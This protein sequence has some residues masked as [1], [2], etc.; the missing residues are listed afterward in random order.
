MKV[1]LG[2]PGTGKTTRLIN[3]VE[4]YLT[5][6]V[7]PDRIGYFAFTRRAAEEAIDRA[8]TQFNLSK[9]ELP[10]FRTLHSLAFLRAGLTHS[11]VM[12]PEKYQE[13]ADWLKI[14]KFYSGSQVEQGPYKDFG[15]GDKFLEIINIARIL[16]KPLRKIYNESIVPLKT[17][18]AR[19]DYVDRGLAHWKKSYGLQDY[20]G[21]LELFVEQELC[22]KLEIVFIDEAQDLSPLQWEM[23]R[24]LE[25][26][27]KVCYVAGDDDQAIFRY[28]GADVEHFIGLEGEVT[29]LNQ[30]YRIPTSHHTLSSKVIK[31][32]VGRREKTFKPR[33]ENGD[34]FWHRHSE[35]VDLSQGDWLL[36]SRT[37][38][39]AQQIEEEVRR[40]GH[41]YIYNGST[42]IDGKVIESVR[43][44]ESL[45][46]GNKLNV[47]Q[48]RLVYKQMLLNSQITY[49]FKTMPDG[50]E[51]VF[52]SIEELQQNHGLLHSFPW[53][54]G[55]GKISSRDRVYIRACL[56]KGESLTTVPRLRIS[57]IHSAKGAQA[58]NVMLL[59]DTMRRPYSMWRKITGYEDDEARVFYV[60]LTR[61]KEKL[62]LI[63]PMFSQGYAL[64][65]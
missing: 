64:P 58:N 48:V 47:N 39:G 41:L 46:E 54:K 21:M 22:P 2:P 57:T 10:Y 36:L 37:T 63:H 32:I 33:E 24:M 29:L 9:K 23:V 17:D 16:R 7:P 65:H 3:L 4:Q 55:L 25:K 40:R 60:G 35:E 53:D 43:L 31:K 38:R 34:I 19:V 15:Y 6:G 13:A 59:T 27:S 12:T 11:Q 5:S 42:S 30:S 50:K 8:C 28:A 14:G 61:A 18:W 44:W 45:R 51:G 20:A 49:G 52:Y 26:N 56:R 62:H 1:V